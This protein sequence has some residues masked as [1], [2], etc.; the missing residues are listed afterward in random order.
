MSVLSME[1]SAYKSMKSFSVN[2]NM[3][4][5]CSVLMIFVLTFLCITHIMAAE[6]PK[7]TE[8]YAKSA[9]LMDA[10]SG[11]ILYEKDAYTAMANASTTKILTCIITLENCDLKSQVTVSGHAAS[12]PKVR[13]GMQEGQQF[14]LEDMLYGLMLESFNDCAVAIAEHIAGSTEGFADMM[15]HRAEEIGCRDSYFITPNGLDAQNENGFHHTTAADLAL[16]MRY[17]IKQSPM[18]D[19]FLKITRTGQYSFTDIGGSRS[20]SC[21]NHNAFLQM[22][23]GAL[24]GKTGFTG[25]AGYCYVGALERDG[26]TYIVALLACGWP[27]NKTYKW[28]DTKKLMS[29]GIE[30]FVKK[31][32][33]EIPVD[34]S[35]LQSIAVVDG[36]GETIGADTWVKP[37]VEEAKGITELL[38]ASGE[39]ISVRYELTDTL[40]APVKEGD[41]VGKITYLLGD[42]VLRECDITAGNSVEKI[43]FSWDLAQILRLFW[44]S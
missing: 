8:L 19:T 9:V 18:A 44:I 36:Q 35:K 26:K 5:I 43:D 42:E 38:V 12:Q 40:Y 25:N 28:S 34:T 17:C 39:E 31:N 13:L 3:K 23:E 20:Y 2:L 27:N 21:T 14:Y 32:L 37:N 10:D 22:M 30:N 4:K 11:R 15:N 1:L 41:Y 7:E 16:I 6:P 24:S 29:Y 33:E